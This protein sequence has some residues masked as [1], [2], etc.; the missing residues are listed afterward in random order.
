MV[1]LEKLIYYIAALF[2][3]NRIL[4]GLSPACLATECHSPS[5]EP[6]RDFHMVMRVQTESFCWFTGGNG[7]V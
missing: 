5:I 7:I 1:V 3:R 6:V 4:M 2:G